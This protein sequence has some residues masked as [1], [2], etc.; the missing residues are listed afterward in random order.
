MLLWSYCVKLT[1][2]ISAQTDTQQQVAA[3]RRLLRAA[4]LQR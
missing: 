3:M 2:N 1:H 4:G